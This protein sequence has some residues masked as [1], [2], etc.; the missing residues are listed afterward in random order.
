MNTKQRNR[1]AI[2]ASEQRQAE[3]ITLYL[4]GAKIDEIAEKQNVSERTVMR[5]INRARK[6]W[7]EHTARNYDELLPEKLIQLEEIRA[8][9]WAGW[10]QSRED[11]E[12]VTVSEK[13]GIT[14]KARGQ[15]GNPAF[16]A[17]LAK[18]LQLE[19]QLRGILENENESTTIPT[20][21]E[22]VI[23]T[24]SEHEEFKTLSFDDYKSTV[25]RKNI[26]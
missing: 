15:S 13:N 5:D 4:G 22:V 17:Q 16:L 11:V 14:K 2:T 12:E 1:R 18:V 9:A 6:K 21:V 7:K 25:E 23:N 10:H 26:A 8:A 20:I 19:C 24:K 3:T